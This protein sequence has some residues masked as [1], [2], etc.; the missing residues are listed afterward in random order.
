MCLIYPER[1]LN[2]QCDILKLILLIAI[3]GYLSHY[4]AGSSAY[5]YPLVYSFFHLIEMP[6]QFFNYW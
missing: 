5:G 3:I 4:V 2:R 6:V 1:P